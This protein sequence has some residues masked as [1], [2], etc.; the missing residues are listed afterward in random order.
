MTPVTW[1]VAFTNPL[2][3]NPVATGLLRIFRKGYRHCLAMRD[4]AGV[5]M[6]YR[7]AKCG[8]VNRVETPG[9]CLVVQLTTANLQTDYF[10]FD[11]VANQQAELAE[12]G[13]TFATATFDGDSTRYVPRGMNCV[14][15]IRA[16]AGLP[17]R[18]QTPWRL[19][20]QLTAMH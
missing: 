19:F 6:H 17:T 11:S 12:K 5:V 14:S 8:E 7:C 10:P 1:T 13:A 4:V 2:G 9:G 20:R 15:V 3:R 18:L 16:L